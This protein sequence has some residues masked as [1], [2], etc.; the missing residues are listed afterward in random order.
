MTLLLFLIPVILSAQDI[1]V[2][3]ENAIQ[4]KTARAWN[5]LAEHLYHTRNNP[6]LLRDATKEAFSILQTKGDTVELGRAYLYASDLYF[7]EGDIN[8]YLR[9]NKTVL[10][11]LKGTQE[12][13]LKEEALNNIAT[14]YGEKDNIDSL[15][16]FT[17]RAIALNLQY[18]GNLGQ[19]GN[20]YQNMAYA[21]SIRGVADSS[22]HYTRETIRV[23]SLAKDTL[24]L[25]D[26]Y[27]QMGVIYVK[28]KDYQSALKYFNKALEVYDQIENKHNRVYIYT[29][30][31][32]MYQKWGDLNKAIV[33]SRKAVYDAQ[34]SHEKITLGKLLCNLGSYLYQTKAYSSSVDTLRK[35]LPLIRNSHYYLG[36]SCQLLA[37]NYAAMQQVDSAELYL[38]L[39]DS[40]ASIK[41][42]V[43]S[44]LFYVS[45]INVLVQQSEHKA[46][47]PYVYKFIEID[48]KKELKESDSE[49]YKL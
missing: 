3:K 43:R 45:K 13:A 17:Q 12:H 20:E 23:L 25:L 49:K 9:S 24:R 5:D 4:Q 15:V 11:I 22:M 32:A 39:V 8:N 7:Q 6:E 33:F 42:F 21:Y 31:A 26:A 47:V 34:H 30:L 18:K 36:A 19:L 2:L 46:A 10:E 41:Q 27:N 16:F 40:L 29:N 14:A 37:G 35:A 1:Q 28:D 38:S 44:E 48:S